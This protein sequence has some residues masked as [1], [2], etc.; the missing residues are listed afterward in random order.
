M[1]EPDYKL[2]NAL[3]DASNLCELALSAGPEG[4]L[5]QNKEFED[6]VGE[7][8]EK[9]IR[10]NEIDIFCI[11]SPFDSFNVIYK[12]EWFSDCKVVAI[13]YDIIPYVMKNHYLADKVTYNLYMKCI[14]MLRWAD[15]IQV[16]SQ[17]VRMI[18]FRI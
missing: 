13:V 15:E 16:I 12:Q 6:V 10:E 8:V 3:E 1:F 14:D 17:S 7:I 11:T 2:S 5:L 4:L 18:W 9:Y